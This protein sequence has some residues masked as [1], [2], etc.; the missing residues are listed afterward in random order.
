M[1]TWLAHAADAAPDGSRKLDQAWRV[2]REAE[3]SGLTGV[4]LPLDRAAL[5]VALGRENVV[6]LA[7]TESAA[8][9][10]LVP[11][12][13]L[14]HFLSRPDDV[15]PPDASGATS[16]VRPA[17][18]IRVIRMPGR[19]TP[20]RLTNRDCPGLLVTKKKSCAG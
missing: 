19:V 3:G 14:L 8:A 17:T 4:T 16:R 20:A 11:L 1:V 6:H 12:S 15:G 2:G 18:A 13:R 9:K 10:R 7:M 5:S